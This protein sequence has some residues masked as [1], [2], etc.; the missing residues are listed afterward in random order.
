MLSPGLV[1]EIDGPY[2]KDGF[3]IGRMILFKVLEPNILQVGL[4]HFV[5]SN[6]LDHLMEQILLGNY[7]KKKKMETLENNLLP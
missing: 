5:L 1:L 3:D 7:L 6:I 4:R 2:F